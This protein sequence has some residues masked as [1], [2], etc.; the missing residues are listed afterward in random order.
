MAY[1]VGIRVVKGNQI[2]YSFTEEIT[3]GAMKQA[4]QTAATIAQSERRVGPVPVKLHKLP[5]Y[6]PID[7][8][9][10][11]V[12][13]REKIPYLQKINDAV[14]AMD[15]RIIKCQVWFSNETSV[16]MIATSDG[17]IVTGPQS[18]DVL[19]KGVK[20]GI[21]VNGFIGGNSNSTTGDFSFGIVGLLIENGEIAHPVN[22]MNISGNADLFWKN[23]AAVGN[24]PYPY[25]SWKTPTLVFEG[26]QFSGV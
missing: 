15:T 14:F 26:I 1:G 4:A 9:W 5:N 3:A 11:K 13:I 22:E 2:G 21:L 6:Y 17:R 16:V 20:K 7:I 23:L 12:P 19:V 18:L 25:G 10:E 8:P 24:D